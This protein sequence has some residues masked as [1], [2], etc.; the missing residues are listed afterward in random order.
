[1]DDDPPRLVAA[2]A[3]YGGV[4]DT[5]W[6]S[7]PADHAYRVRSLHNIYKA[8]SNYTNAGQIGRAAA[9]CNQNPQAWAM[10]SGIMAEW[11]SQKKG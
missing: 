6:L 8:F 3:R 7:M 4:G 11:R 9:W 5:V 2:A 1:M 10:I